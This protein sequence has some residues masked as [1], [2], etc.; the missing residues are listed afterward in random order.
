MPD[1]ARRRGARPATQR[2]GRTAG[3]LRLAGLLAVTAVVL[4]LQALPASAHASF[5]TSQPAPDTDLAAAP[6]VVVLEFSE[7]MI[8]DL[9]WVTVTDP[10]GQQFTARPSDDLTISVDVDSTM[11]GVYEVEWKTVSPIDS[12]SW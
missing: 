12:P 11:Q 1:P 2:S 10:T 9:S 6:G 4:L 3:P 5:V 8:Q 7:P